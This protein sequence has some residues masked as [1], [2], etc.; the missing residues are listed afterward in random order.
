MLS[1]ALL[2]ASERAALGVWHRWAALRDT[3]PTRC[4]AITQPVRGDGQPDRRGGFASVAPRGAQAVHFRLS[5]PRRARA[6]ITLAIGE[7][8]FALTGDTRTARA[9]DAATDRAVIGAMRG[10]GSMSLSYVAANG[11][12]V[13]EA[14]ALDGAATAIDAAAIGCAR[15]GSG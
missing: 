8:R 3:Q 14:Y 4:F 1:L 13:A 2:L 5:A 7:R 11:R 9:P 10:G 15:V 6:P 12:P